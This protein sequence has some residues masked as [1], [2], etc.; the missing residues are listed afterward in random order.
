MWR[1]VVWVA[2]FAFAA[3]ERENQE[4]T[5]DESLVDSFPYEE[6]S[7]SMKKISGRSLFITPTVIRCPERFHYNPYIERCVK[8]L[9]IVRT[10][11]Q[12]L[13]QLNSMFK[14]N[15]KSRNSP[16]HKKNH[17][18]EK[19]REMYQ[20]LTSTYPTLRIRHSGSRRVNKNKT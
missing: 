19:L 13:N 3:A 1:R 15:L 2:C 17:R 4:H 12:L 20:N 14:S 5:L 8:P 16:G 6:P 7:N 9:R 18:K 11:E 10:E